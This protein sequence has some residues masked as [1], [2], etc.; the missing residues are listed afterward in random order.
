[1]SASFIPEL[2]AQDEGIN[3]GFIQTLNVVGSNIDIT[4]SSG[5]GTLEE[6]TGGSPSIYI[7]K[8]GDEVNGDLSFTYTNPQIIFFDRPDT[9]TGSYLKLDNNI[10]QLF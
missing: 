9:Q 8:A 6:G 7:L 2:L 1:M 10:F 4:T 5:V 3:Q